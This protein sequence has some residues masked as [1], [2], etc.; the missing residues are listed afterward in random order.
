MRQREVPAWSA[1][2]SGT[3]QAHGEGHPAEAGPEL[4][5]G[6]AL[7]Q[8]SSRSELSGAR[9][10]S[11][12]M[13]FGGRAGSAGWQDMLVAAALAGHTRWPWAPAP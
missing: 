8:F 3:T 9:R 11:P 12:D 7:P 2:P 1:E 13:F 4:P 10:D 6:A 5:W